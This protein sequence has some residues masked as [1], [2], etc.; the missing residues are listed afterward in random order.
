MALHYLCS[1]GQGSA[2]SA[3]T[4]SRLERAPC[5]VLEDGRLQEAYGAASCGWWK[6]R[7]R[8]RPRVQ[9]K[10]VAP[11][12]RM[13]EAN[14]AVLSALLHRRTRAQPQLPSSRATASGHPALKLGQ[15]R[16]R[17]VARSLQVCG[18]IGC[19]FLFAR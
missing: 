11:G 1:V 12:G 7:N 13:A 5:P 9:S 14:L 3:R 6:L 10:A 19:I 2:R 4:E 8:P 18:L 17:F 16:I 15:R